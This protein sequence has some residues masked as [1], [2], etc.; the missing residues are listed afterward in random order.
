MSALLHAAGGDAPWHSNVRSKYDIF[1]AAL[2][3][4]VRAA[5][6]RLDH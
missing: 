4:E 5:G 2:A 6:F 1:T 3:A